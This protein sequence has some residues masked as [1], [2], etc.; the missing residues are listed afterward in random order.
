VRYEYSIPAYRHHTSAVL[1]ILLIDIPPDTTQIKFPEACIGDSISSNNGTCRAALAKAILE[2]HPWLEETP[3]DLCGNTCVG[4]LRGKIADLKLKW[5][6]KFQCSPKGQG[7]AG[8]FIGSGR[9]S[10][11]IGAI[12]DWL[13]KA[14]YA[15]AINDD[16]FK[17]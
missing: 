17:C 14:S 16:D 13:M 2:I 11:M 3:R 7:I 10:S 15:G 5:D 12:T 1:I 4:N 6:A 8:R 9:N